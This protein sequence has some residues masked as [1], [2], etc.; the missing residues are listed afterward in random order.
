MFSKLNVKGLTRPRGLEIEFF[1]PVAEKREIN[2]IVV[3]GYAYSLREPS[4]IVDSLDGV[5]P[6]NQMPVFKKLNDN[7]YLYYLWVNY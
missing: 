6:K 5:S 7:W 2:R 1:L 4:P 3:K